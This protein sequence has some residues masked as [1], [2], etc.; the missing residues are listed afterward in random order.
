MGT[1]VHKKL[2]Q[3][4]EGCWYNEWGVKEVSLAELYRRIDKWT[5]FTNKGVVLKFVIDD[6]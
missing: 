2:G 6:S 4:W 1:E 5:M 3:F